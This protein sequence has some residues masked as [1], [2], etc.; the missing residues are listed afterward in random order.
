M[1][2]ERL[3]RPSGFTRLAIGLALTLGGALLIVGCGTGQKTEEA[4]PPEAP[5]PSEQAAPAPSEQAAPAPAAPAESAPA[6]AVPTPSATTPSPVPSAP[7][8]ASATLEPKSGSKVT[9]TAT[10]TQTD[11]SV[12]VKV[13]LADATPGEHGIHLHETGDCSA[14]DASSAG[15]HFNPAGTPH[16][17]PDSPQHH[18]G[19]FGNITV[20]S[21]GKGT[22]DLTRSDITVGEGPSS[23][24][25]RSIVIH[26]MVDD[27]TTQPSGNSGARIACGVIH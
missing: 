5:A 21:D 26:E 11:G 24:V 27:L 14:L 2:H 18:A 17:G 23:V 8:T 15:G 19:D 1:R 7:M 25:G 4:P 6:P 3:Q 10:F 9:G 22:L 20:G 13:E 12:Q 16:G